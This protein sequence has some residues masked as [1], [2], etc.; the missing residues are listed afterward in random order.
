MRTLIEYGKRGT[1]LAGDIK[2]VP[3][4]EHAPYKKQ[5]EY[6]LTLRGLRTFVDVDTD[7][8]VKKKLEVITVPLFGEGYQLAR[9]LADGRPTVFVHTQTGLRQGMMSPNYDHEGKERLAAVKIQLLKQRAFEVSTKLWLPDAD[10]AVYLA[11]VTALE[12]QGVGGHDAPVEQDLEHRLSVLGAVSLGDITL[13]QEHGQ[14]AVRERGSSVA[15]GLSNYKLGSIFAEGS[16]GG[17]EGFDEPITFDGSENGKFMFIP[18]SYVENPEQAFGGL[19]DTSPGLAP[20]GIVIGA[21]MKALEA[22]N[23]LKDHGVYQKAMIGGA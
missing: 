8:G 21:G 7:L 2:T 1:E 6:L 12:A 13:A 3:N 23:M 18:V 17:F 16:I 20:E 14:H 19:M 11:G 4:V 5:L 22:R 9:G 10:D 15:A